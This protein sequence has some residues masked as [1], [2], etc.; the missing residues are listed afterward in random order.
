[1]AEELLIQRGHT[2]VGYTIGMR[3]NTEEIFWSRSERQPSGCLYLL[4][5]NGHPTTEFWF[6][7]RQ[8]IA[9][10]LA[11]RFSRGEDPEVWNVCHSCDDCLCIEPAHLW[12][13]TGKDNQ[14]DMI[15][16]GRGREGEKCGRAKLSDNQCRRIYKEYHNGK[17][18]VRQV[19][20]AREYGVTQ[21]TISRIVNKRRYF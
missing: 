3:P 15:L 12:K 8:Q 17:R 10:R 4:N 2:P 19:D 16:K 11:Y 14:Q 6:E 7:N 21:I 20:L 18:K 9:S 1:M 5:T 13:G